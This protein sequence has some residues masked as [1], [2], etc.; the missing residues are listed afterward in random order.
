[1]NTVAQCYGGSSYGHAGL[2][3]RILYEHLNPNY[4]ASQPSKALY[5]AMAVPGTTTHFVLLAEYTTRTSTGQILLTEAVCTSLL[6]SLR[7]RAYRELRLDCLP[8]V[9]WNTGLN[10]SSPLG[11]LGDYGNP[12]VGQDITTWSRL[13]TID[14]CLRPGPITVTSVMK[15]DGTHQYLF[16]LFHQS[17]HI[18]YKLAEAWKLRESPVVNVQWDIT[19][20]THPEQW[21]RSGTLAD[22]RR[23]LGIRIFK[24]IGGKQVESWLKPRRSDKQVCVVN[25]IID[26]LTDKI[27]GHDYTWKP[28]HE[29]IFTEMEEY[30]ADRAEAGART[31][32]DRTKRKRAGMEFDESEFMWNDGERKPETKPEQHQRRTKKARKDTR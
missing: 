29:Y 10:G 21:A 4:R 8:A 7:T 5:K 2:Q 13:R 31:S 16:A 17:F 23:C 20:G 3:N 18:P 30:L 25:T 27:V 14:N 24:E 15:K 26:L 6:G 12:Q 28:T 11:P 22:E 9:D 1:M 32:G 19:K